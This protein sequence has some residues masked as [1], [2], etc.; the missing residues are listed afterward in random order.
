L[1]RREW[2]PVAPAWE[3]DPDDKDIWR[4]VVTLPALALNQAE[5]D[6]LGVVAGLN[7]VV[8]GVGTGNAALALAAM[9]ARVTVVD[10]SLSLLDMLM[11]RTRLVG[12]EIAFQRCDLADITSLG[13]GCAQLVYAAQVAPRVEDLGRFYAGVY[14][15]LSARGRLV[16]T[17]YHPFR[18]IWLQEPGSPRVKFSYF[19]RRRE[20]TDD[21]PGD[22]S[23]ATDGFSRHDFQWTVSDH[24]HYLTEAG[25]RVTAIEEVG[26]VR[27]HWEMPNLKGLPEQLIIGAD[28][29]EQDLVPG[30]AEEQ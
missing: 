24:F 7:T 12:V 11:V 3:R 6:L 19:E 28:R 14:R 1:K 23:G 4:R 29:P 18:R 17:E 20:Y 5:R 9:G 16:V 15:V 8:V 25:L 10:P 13:E 27:Q 26:E 2:V 22:P 21:W 30:R